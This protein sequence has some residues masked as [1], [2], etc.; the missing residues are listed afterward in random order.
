[1]K[2]FFGTILQLI[3]LVT[4][5]VSSIATTE[6]VCERKM[7]YSQI[8]SELDYSNKTQ[9]DSQEIALL[10]AAAFGIILFVIGLILLITKTK[11]Q[12][13]LEAELTTFKY[14]LENGEEQDNAIGDLE[15]LFELKQKGILTEEEFGAIKRKLIE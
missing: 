4:I 12:R 15:R 7:L 1:M 3:G 11:K 10:F 6:L 14:I 9:I 2:K 13:Q 8:K 5:I